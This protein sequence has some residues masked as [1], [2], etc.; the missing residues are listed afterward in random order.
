M[1]C[2]NARYACQ[3]FIRDRELQNFLLCRLKRTFRSV[4][5]QLPNKQRLLALR[6]DDTGVVFRDAI[7]L[8]RLVAAAV[9]AA[10]VAALVGTAVLATT[11]AGFV[12]AAMVA[13]AVTALIRAAMV[14]SAAALVTATV[15]A[16]AVA[17][18]APSVNAGSNPVF[19][20]FN[21][22]T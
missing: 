2:L 4:S 3:H 9:L 15:V 20:T 21:M 11:V 18:A 12:A 6:L 16:A 1:R 10:T 5:N 19:E 7:V 14:T 22:E 13:A 8:G 17:V